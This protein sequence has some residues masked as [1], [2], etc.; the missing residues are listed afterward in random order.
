VTGPKRRATAS[1]G[2]D[3]SLNYAAVGATQSPDVVL[4]P[5]EGFR[6]FQSSRRI[7]SGDERFD[8]ASRAL[9]TWGVHRNS[10]IPVTDIVRDPNAAYTGIEYDAAG[11]PL[12]PTPPE[13]ELFSPDGTPYVSAGMTAV[14]HFHL[15][16]IDVKAPV[17]VVYV[18]DEPGKVGFAYGSR[19]GHPARAEQLQYVEQEEDGS[20]WLTIRSIS[21]PAGRRTG[22]TVGLLRLAQRHYGR[23]FMTALHPTRAAGA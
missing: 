7:G 13:E 2:G 8:I 16:P 22:L 3:A 12:G 5:P 23:R 9:M 21:S 11:R 20:V 6:P 10:G 4:Y 17:K 1:G 14:M 19:H 15:G 18:L